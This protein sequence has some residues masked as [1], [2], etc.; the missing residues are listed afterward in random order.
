MLR[1]TLI[2]KLAIYFFISNLEKMIDF[3]SLA[4]ASFG[5]LIEFVNSEM[6]AL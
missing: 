6:Q 2:L 5:Y 4:F 1:M 3:Y